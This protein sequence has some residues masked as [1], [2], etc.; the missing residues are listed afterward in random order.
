MF[1]L[2]LLFD[3]LRSVACCGPGTGHRGMNKTMPGAPT[4]GAA[5][6][7]WVPALHGQQAH[8][9][10]LWETLLPPHLQTPASE[11]IGW[12]QAPLGGF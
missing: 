5:T 6:R 10:R 11:A 9:E 3:N 8:L 2:S 1:S 7:G 4:Q 12:Q